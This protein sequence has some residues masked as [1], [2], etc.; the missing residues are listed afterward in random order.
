[1]ST[2]SREKGKGN[3]RAIVTIGLRNP[4]H[5]IR[6]HYVVQKRSRLSEGSGR[7]N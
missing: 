5:G 7:I 4:K 6:K 3:K 2:D 1:M